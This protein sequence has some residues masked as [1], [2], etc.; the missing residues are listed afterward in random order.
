MP[1]SGFVTRTNTTDLTAVYAYAE[2]GEGAAWKFSNVRRVHLTTGIEPGYALCGIPIASGADE[3]A[4]TVAGIPGGPMGQIKIGTRARVVANVGNTQLTVLTGSVRQIEG[5]FGPEN[6]ECSVEIVD[7]RWLLK[8][9]PVVGQWFAD[10]SATGYAYR[11]WRAHVEPN[12]QPNC[13]FRTVSGWPGLVPMFCTPNYGLTVDGEI[14]G[15]NQASQT[16]ACHWT[17]ILLL[18]YLRFATSATA[19]GLASSSFDGFY[20]HV[21]PNWL[22][23]WPNGWASAIESDATANYRNS[24]ER[25][26][27]SQNVLSLIQEILDE[28]GGYS[29]G[30]GPQVSQNADKSVS[31]ESKL[32]VVRT[33]YNGTGLTLRSPS[34]VGEIGTP[35]VYTEGSLRE[36]GHNLFTVVSV[37]GRPVFIERRVATTSGAGLQKAWGSSDQTAWLNI[38]KAASTQDEGIEAANRKYPHVFNAYRLHPTFDFQSGTSED[39]KPRAQ[40]ARP[41]LPTLLSTFLETD[42]AASAA[43]KIRFRRPVLV[44]YDDG[45]GYAVGEYNDGFTLDGDGTLSF[46]GLRELRRTFTISGTHGSQTVTANE[47]RMTLAIPCDHRS[48]ETRILPPNEGDADRVEA[49]L[50]RYYFG[51]AGQ[52]YGKEIRHSSSYPVPESAGG[53]APGAA[54]LLDDT[55]KLTDHTVLKS[56]EL[57][58]LDRG[59]TFVT[60]YMSFT[61]QPGQS[62]AWIAMAGNANYPVRGVVLSVTFEMDEPNERTIVEVGNT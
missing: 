38:V 2:F 60:P 42:A 10:D 9:L 13:V 32:Q 33:R 49:N 36:A 3:E 11:E 27:E 4:P 62:I 35:K 28:V 8:S 15:A 19:A 14:P 21:H 6:D 39:G 40:V 37:A 23:T 18:E 1:A 30:L 20:P 31:F 44:E 24:K 12:G 47:L 52:V 25:V 54:T 17:P 22:C 50:I 53:T 57:M 26:L 56:R 34:A 48:R 59:G 55:E 5:E 7:D 61:Q 58:R 51:D 29:V 16:Q 46:S 45:G 43:E 41:V